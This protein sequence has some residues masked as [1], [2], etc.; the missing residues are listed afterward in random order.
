MAYKDKDRQKQANKEASRRYRESKQGMTNQGI[1]EGMTQATTVIPD[2]TGFTMA[3]VKAL[4]AAQCKAILNSWLA[5]NG[6]A[7]QR[8]LALLGRAY[9]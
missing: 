6:S 1:A 9:A 4:T 5:G 3:D 8:N 7:Y 2:T